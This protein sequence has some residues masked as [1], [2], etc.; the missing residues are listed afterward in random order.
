MPEKFQFIQK[1][2]GMKFEWSFRLTYK[3]NYFTNRV[4]EIN[5][6]YRI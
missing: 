1:P 3:P 6:S 5:F 4:I 2:K